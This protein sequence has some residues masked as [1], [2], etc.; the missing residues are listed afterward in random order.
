[1][2]RCWLGPGSRNCDSQ[3]VGSLTRFSL[4]FRTPQKAVPRATRGLPGD[5][6]VPFG[7]R[8][9]TKMLPKW[10]PKVIESLD[11]CNSDFDNPYCTKPMFLLPQGVKNL[12][13]NRFKFGTH[14]Q[15]RQ[16]PVLF[17]PAV[18]PGGAA[19]PQSRKNG[20]RKGDPLAPGSVTESK[21]GPTWGQRCPK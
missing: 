4:I 17:S 11:R 14:S 7:A 2:G 15:M 20:S 19:G 18:V 13:Q 12:I 9:E 16:K 10:R 3:R 6:L 21:P 8:F 1:M 5:P